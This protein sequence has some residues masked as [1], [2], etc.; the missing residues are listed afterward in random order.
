MLTTMVSAQ[1]Y[2][3]GDISMLKKFLDEGAVYKDKDGNAVEPLSFMKTE[4][5]NAMRVRLFVDP[6]K[7]S[8]QHKKEGVIQDLDYV[9][10]L[11]K[12]IKEAGFQFM[13]DFHYS[14]TWTDPGKH[15]TPSAWTSLNVEQMKAKIAEYTKQCLQELKQAGAEPDFIQTGN[16]ITTGMLWFTGQ[17]YAGGGAPA[18]GS[19]NNFAGYLASAIKACNEECPQAKIVI[20]TE[21]HAP[22]DV[23]KFY[24]NLKNYQD[25]KYDIIGLSYYPDFHGDLTVLDNTLT[26]LET[27]YPDKKIMIV[28][29]G[30]G[31]EWQLSGA[32]HNFTSKWPVSEDGQKLFTTDLIA[33][34]Q[35]HPNVNGLFWW[36]PEYTLNNIV[37]KNDSE[38]WSKDF[39]SGYWNAAL[40]HYKTGRALSALYELKN[41]VGD[42]TGIDAMNHEPITN[43]RS[44]Y[45]LDG[46][47]LS[48]QPTQKGIYIHQGKKVIVK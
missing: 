32:K 11:G 37:F 6:S 3:G 31:F 7:A 42:D 10:A 1:K 34:L 14:D 4:G 39:T 2:V 44:W 33:A 47:R 18:G 9:K 19:W 13:L 24:N 21:M 38:D 5:W 22:A 20:H 28:E 40:F 17:I 12:S 8:A 45:T 48:A 30:Y 23:P 41:F 43:N 16:E 15:A 36:Y 25:V 26:T 46:R 27:N 35:T 29:T